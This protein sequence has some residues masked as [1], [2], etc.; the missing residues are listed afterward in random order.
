[1]LLLA[2]FASCT[3][4]K[5]EKA[6]N[7]SNQEILEAVSEVHAIGKITSAEDWAVVAAGAQGIIQKIMVGEGET[8]RADQTLIMREAENALRELEQGNGERNRLK[9]QYTA[10]EDELNTVRIHAAEWKKKYEG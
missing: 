9:A 1:A 10:K 8:M 4:K 6:P 5:E 3:S 2:L 7:K